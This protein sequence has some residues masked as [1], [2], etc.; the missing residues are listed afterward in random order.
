MIPVNGSQRTIND[1]EL[2]TIRQKSFV[3][4]NTFKQG[5]NMAENLQTITSTLEEGG[6]SA[7]Q[8]QPAQITMEELRKKYE[9]EESTQ[10]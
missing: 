1:I 4:K 7:E 9:M 8:L 6:I 2:D 10:E 5:A 3:K